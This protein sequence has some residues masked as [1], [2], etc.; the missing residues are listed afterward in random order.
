VVEELPY[1][2]LVETDALRVFRSGC[3]GFRAYSLFAEEA[4]CD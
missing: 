2:W 3:D 1:L 4:A